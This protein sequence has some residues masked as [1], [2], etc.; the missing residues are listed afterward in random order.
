MKQSY[1]KPA[2]TQ[3]T[4][5]V[6][7]ETGEI[8]KEQTL[9][10]SYIANSREEFSLLYSS[11]SNVI[12]NLSGPAI[13]TYFFLLANYKPGNLIAINRTIKEEIKKSILVTSV[14]TIS[15]CLTE[16]TKANLLLRKIEGRGGYI[17]NSR[18]AYKGSS[19]DRN[20]NLK[21]LMQ[22]ICKTA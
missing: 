19:T 10:H 16:L 12:V 3:T 14:G 17:I 7:T 5:Y 6:D 4:K 15:N 8:I 18:Y 9:T 2:L 22:N 21:Y 20:Q 11:I 1:L 13:K